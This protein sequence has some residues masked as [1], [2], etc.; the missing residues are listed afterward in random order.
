M[1]LLR[2]S[3][4]LAAILCLACGSA[5]APAIPPAAFLP[6]REA[7]AAPPAPVAATPA[8]EGPLSSLPYSPVLDVASMDRSADP[9][10]SLYDYSGG[11]WRRSN[12]IPPDQ[13]SWD[14][15]AKLTQEIQRFLW[16]V[17]EELTPVSASRTPR[18]SK[19]G[20]YFA[21]CMDE[22]GVDARGLTP[23][24]PS[25]DAIDALA[26]VHDLAPLL[27]RLQLSAGNGLLFGF[28]SEQDSDDATRMIAVASAGG[29]GLPDRDYYT[30]A[31]AKSEAIRTKYVAHVARMLALLGDPEATALRESESILRIETA[32]ARASLTRVDRRD[33]YKVFH[34]T[35]IEALEAMTPDFAWPVFL[36][37]L[38]AP[39]V[40]VLN[41]AQPAFFKEL[42]ELL[43]TVPVAEW[44]TYLRWR[45]VDARAQHL[46]APFVAE[47]FDFYRRTLRG[48]PSPPPRWKRCVRMVDD[49]LGEALGEEFVHRTFSP[50]TKARA[51]AMTA[52]IER[53]METDI[54]SLGWMTPETK[55]QAK[56]KLHAIVNM[57]GYPDR[58]RDY[59]AVAV[60][61]D[62]FA[63][64]VARA[65]EFEQ[66][67]RI[68]QIGKPVDRTE[69]HMTAPTVNAY[70]NSHLNS[71]NFPAGVL[72]PP[73]F[74]ARDND[75]PS[76]GD[77]GS[78]I[79]H[80]LTHGFDDHGRKFD[81][82]G[83]L[84]D[85]WTKKDAAAFDLQASC[86]VNQYAEYVVV[87]DIHINGK[88][89]LGEDVADLGGT[90][91]AYAAWKHATSAAHL[92]AVEGLSPDQQFFVGFA[93]WAC[94][95]SRPEQLRV[96]AVTDSHSPAKYR[97]DGVAA[98]M[99]E[100]ARAFACNAGRP[101]V[102]A[103]SCRVW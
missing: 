87:D 70:Y 50:G 58:P 2:L 11:G 46:S 86:V 35:R 41:V 49:Q 15:Y 80:E 93:Q 90:M 76:Y 101:M 51:A 7:S 44:R 72:L 42:A 18:Q 39:P 33:P 47:D 8:P 38:A 6:V 102:R 73:F 24:K 65:S 48:V 63:G 27:A 92:A 83:N 25:L 78:T 74:D 82:R 71:I 14:E 17:I 26:S 28:T 34:K 81:E 91:L 64:N 96:R 20:D 3:A 32:L 61:R 19:L 37:T 89:T 36:A 94:E 1:H 29:L 30:K 23:I 54:T 12:P 40:R 97:I 43:H 84:K 52:E 98:N 16:G 88:L 66:R 13:A 21:A 62:D 95:S 4:P 99:P 9:C 22:R 56:A 67:R 77:T 103:Q 60:A 68:A 53:E 79:G 31:D 57:I 10:V 5:P 59:G 45:L 69:W 85:W 75:A 55:R 100:F